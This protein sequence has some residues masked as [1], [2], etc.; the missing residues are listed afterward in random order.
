MYACIDIHTCWSKGRTA[1]P[2]SRL[3]TRRGA[4]NNNNNNSNNNNTNN[5]NINSTYHY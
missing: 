5:N 2:A 4:P 1:G 3:R